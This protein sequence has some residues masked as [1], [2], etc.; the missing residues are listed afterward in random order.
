MHAWQN[1][2]TEV[3]MDPRSCAE[4]LE[5]ELPRPRRRLARIWRIGLWVVGVEFVLCIY[6]FATT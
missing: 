1:D 2:L 5:I 4:T 6:L 3:E